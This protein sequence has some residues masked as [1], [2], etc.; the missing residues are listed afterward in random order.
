MSSCPKWPHCHG[1]GGSGG[2]GGW[3]ALV[4]I[5]VVVAVAAKVGQAVARGAEEAARVLAVVFEVVLIALG[6]AA[7]IGVLAV[8]I[9]VG[10][11]LRRRQLARQAARVPPLAPLVNGWTLAPVGTHQRAAVALDAVR[12]AIEPSRIIDP[13]VALPGTARSRAALPRK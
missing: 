11:R 7:G 12:P 10:V 4:V 13:G 5:A 2:G 8:L 1:A 6:S 9:W 3:V